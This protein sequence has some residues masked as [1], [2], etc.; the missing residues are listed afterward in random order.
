V[1]PLHVPEYAQATVHL[2]LQLFGRALHLEELIACANGLDYAALSLTSECL[3]IGA[4]CG[5]EVQ[6]SSL[7]LVGNLY[8]FHISGCADP[9]GSRRQALA[10]DGTRP[11]AES[12]LSY[13]RET[14]LAC[15]L[16][17]LA[18]RR[19]ILSQFLVHLRPNAELDRLIHRK[20]CHPFDRVA[21]Q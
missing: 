20:P 13:A 18:L 5:H 8:L 3:L 10:I 1:W 17:R 19:D 14:V 6:T 11:L 2:H 15:H 21:A 16:H 9:S 4:L 7:D 12:H